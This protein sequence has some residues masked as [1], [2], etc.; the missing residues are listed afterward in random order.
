LS[1]G[2]TLLKKGQSIGGHGGRKFLDTFLNIRGRHFS[3]HGSSIPRAGLKQRVH[4]RQRSSLHGGISVRA[5]SFVLGC[6]RTKVPSG[7]FTEGNPPAEGAWSCR[8]RAKR[9][10]F[11]SFDGSCF[12]AGLRLTVRSTMEPR[13]DVKGVSTSSFDFSLLIRLW[14]RDVR[15]VAIPCV[16]EALPFDAM[17]RTTPHLS[18]QR[19]CSRALVIKR[20]RQ[21]R[22]ASLLCSPWSNRSKITFVALS[23]F[24][25]V[26]SSFGWW[27]VAMRRPIRD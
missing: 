5:V 24:L 10:Y 19:S 3:H 18:K 7:A 27:V 17:M 15:R 6:P 25:W 2:R 11:S 12:P 16:F 20:R 8:W 14:Q 21:L 26:G 13:T 22:R 1:L 23:N 4:R 9:D